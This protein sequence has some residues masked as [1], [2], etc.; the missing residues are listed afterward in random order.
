MP[1]QHVG[2]ET[3]MVSVTESCVC[4]IRSDAPPAKTPQSTKA[5]AKTAEQQDGSTPAA[6]QPTGVQQ[7][8]MWSVV[9][10]LEYY[11]LAGAALRLL[12]LWPAGSAAKSSKKGVRTFPNGLKIENVAMGQP[13]G[14]LAKA[15]KRVRYLLN[16]SEQMVLFV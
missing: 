2:C 10:M 9:T 7:Q 1:Q 13:D 11:Q 3:D 12:C 5:K 6:S 8:A 14:K 4:T 16:S 15:G